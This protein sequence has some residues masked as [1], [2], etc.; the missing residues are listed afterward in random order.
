MKNTTDGEIV[1]M[2]V[3]MLNLLY[4][5]IHKMSV[6]KSLEEKARLKMEIRILEKHTDVLERIVDEEFEV[7]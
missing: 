6:A 3:D 1:D 5:N 2:A 7:R 4:D